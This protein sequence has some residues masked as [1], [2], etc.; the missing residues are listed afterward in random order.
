[1]SIARL[2]TIIWICKLTVH[3]FAKINNG[4]NIPNIV[5]LYTYFFRV[6]WKG[7]GYKLSNLSMFIT[8]I[9]MPEEKNA[10]LHVFTRSWCPVVTFSCFPVTDLGMHG[11]EEIWK[12]IR[13]F[14]L[15]LCIFVMLVMLCFAVGIKKMSIENQCLRNLSVIDII[16]MLFF[17]PLTLRSGDN[18][19]FLLHVDLIKALQL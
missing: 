4:K 2:F 11:D 3:I 6:I 5:I 16:L 10:V 12:D 14:R 13:I 18:W 1:M 8:L 7:Y 9:I 19:I 17:V 15:C